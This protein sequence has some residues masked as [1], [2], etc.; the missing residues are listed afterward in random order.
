MNFLDQML[1]A[2]KIPD[3]LIRIG[4]RDL[5]AK[6]EK[7]ELIADPIAAQ[8]RIME[9][10]RGIQ[11][12]PLA[13]KTAEANEQHYEVPTQFFKYC[14]GKNLKYSSCLYETGNES[15]DEAEDLMLDLT[16]QRA[17][18]ANGQDVLELGCGWGS[19]TLYMA[20][21]F[22]ESMI[23]AVSN[24][25]TQKEHIDSEANVR[26]LKNIRVITADMNTFSLDETF[27]RVVSVEMFEHMKN[28]DELLAKV[29]RL[30]KTGGKLFVHIFTHIN[31]AY[32]FE[33]TDPS[34]WITRYFF[35][36]GQMPSDHLLLY[37]QNDLKIENHWR[38]N[39]RHYAQTAEHWLENM[40]SHK[41]EILPLFA[42]T[43]G[44][45]EVTR[46]WNYW[47]IFYMSCAELWGWKKGTRWIVSHYLFTKP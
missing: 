10:I 34:D 44:D 6:K 11:K 36:G 21:H 17:G 41:A 39:G 27:D 12:T 18:L 23:T 29:S 22:P 19:L 40:D 26:G 1:A 3:A 4:I 24:S 31:I 2:G 8:E 28:Y 37:F 32:H 47:R 45:A 46:W 35:E 13:I 20:K 16:C 15:L 14:L 9:H 5:L 25:R 33:G 7:A 43:Y 42:K 38:V 30:L